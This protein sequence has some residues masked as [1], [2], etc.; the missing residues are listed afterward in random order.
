MSKWL[1]NSSGTPI[2]FISGNNVFLKSGTFLGKLQGD[3]VWNGNYIGE[4]VKD[5]YLARKT[6]TSHASRVSL[7]TPASPV[8]PVQPV[9]RVGTSL[10][11]GFEDIKI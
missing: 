4:I 11:S 2:A 3:E 7:V 10:P 5:D 8:S 9:G 1:Y 6:S